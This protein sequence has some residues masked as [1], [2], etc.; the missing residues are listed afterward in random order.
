MLSFDAV[1]NFLKQYPKIQRLC[2]AFSG[3][4]DSHVLL[5]AL[6]M[7]SA[8]FSVDCFAIHIEHGL[9]MNSNDWQSHCAD[10]CR[11]L[12]IPFQSVSIKLEKKPGDSLEAIARTARYDALADFIDENTALLTAHHQDDQAETLLLQLLRG[13]GIQGLSGMPVQSDFSK[14]IHWRPLLA[15][16]RDDIIQYANQYNLNWIEDNSNQD[17][18][19]DRNYLRQHIFPM[20][21]ERWPSCQRTI[22]R[23]AGH[24]ADAA[25]IIQQSAKA[26]WQHCADETRLNIS[27]LQQLPSER[28]NHCLRYWLSEQSLPLPNEKKIHEIKQQAYYASSDANPII[29]W[30]GA[31]VRRYRNDLYAYPPTVPAEQG[32]SVWED[33]SQPLA[34]ADQKTILLAEKKEGG[35]IFPEG[36]IISVRY[37]RGGE[38]IHPYDK[39]H[40]IS[41]KKYWQS[42]NV[43]PW[44]RDH[45]PLIYC[46]D[47]LAAVV[48]FTMSKS[49][50]QAGNAWV[51]SKK[52]RAAS[53]SCSVSTDND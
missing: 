48:G 28:Q 18:R 12:S 31:L 41:L 39:T 42:L 16:S 11:D 30:D 46:D 53:S 1:Q 29:E 8:Q 21:K 25:K 49:F 6:K 51:F 17:D 22:S 10:V 13:A 40:S 37:R 5:H 26:D 14:G 3:G 23:S 9:N 43:P 45:I 52:A 32:D 19:F 15:V 7:M 47:N 2:V 35:V 50:Y 38:R 36:A 27:L 44:L 4:V 24:C 34:L 33:L 20:L